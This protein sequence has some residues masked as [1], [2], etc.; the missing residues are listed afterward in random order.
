MDLLYP[1]IRKGARPMDE[2]IMPLKGDF[3]PEN[4]REWEATIY[5]QACT[6]AQKHATTQLKELDEALLGQRPADWRVVGFRERTLVARF[7]EVRFRR[8]LYRDEHGCYRFLLDEYLGLPAHQAATEMGAN[9]SGISK[10]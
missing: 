3:A 4:A 2:T 1:D 9:G 5:R 6:E 7:G 10:R 8:R